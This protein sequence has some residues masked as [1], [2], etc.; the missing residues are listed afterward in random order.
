MKPT[1]SPLGLRALLALAL[2]AVFA[3]PAQAAAPV[4]IARL[5]TTTIKSYKSDGTDLNGGGFGGG[6]SMGYMFDG[7]M[8]NGARANGIGTKGYLILDFGASFFVETIDVTKLYRYK[9]SIFFSPS[10][11]GDD[12]VQVPYASNV[13]RINTK[14]WGLFAVASRVKFVFEEGGSIIPDVAEIEVWGVPASEME[15]NHASLSSWT[16][17]PNSATCTSPSSEWATCSTC[18]AVFTRE[19]GG[20]PLGHDY[21]AN[22]VSSGKGWF[23]CNRCHD[24]INCSDGE[25]DLTSFGGM[26][27]D[28]TKVQFTDV[29]TSQYDIGEQWGARNDTFVDNNINTRWTGGSTTHNSTIKFATDVQLTKITVTVSGA[30]YA[31]WYY[32]KVTDAA[33]G[34]TLLEPGRYLLDSGDEKITKTFAFS[35]KTAKEINVSVWNN[36][37]WRVWVD[38]IRVYGTVLG[39]VNY[40]PALILMQ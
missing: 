22:V 18:G 1:S 28:E 36:G 33:T 9:Y 8:S 39:E 2:A 23:L 15:C 13:N 25:V 24:V 40:T 37:G 31:M 17:V 3:L 19:S 4:N 11:S 5:Q 14:K 20:L 6:S 34:A 27:F 7:N 38:E 16:E 21:R 26:S 35:N 10:A 12:W 29:S 30:D 32:L